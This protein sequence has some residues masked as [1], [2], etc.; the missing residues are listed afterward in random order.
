VL[1]VK[2]GAPYNVPI[3]VNGIE[4]ENSTWL[5]KLYRYEVGD[6]RPRAIGVLLSFLVCFSYG[7]VNAVVLARPERQVAFECLGLAV[8]LS[9]AIPAIQIFLTESVAKL[10]NTAHALR[11]LVL[12]Y[13]AAI[14]LVLALWKGITTQVVDIIKE[15]SK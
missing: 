1:R 13:S 7:I 4:A 3:T 8:I 2:A 11:I 15:L 9:L 12:E 6:V 5:E 10:E 14:V